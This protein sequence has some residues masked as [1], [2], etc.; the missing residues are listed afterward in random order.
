MSSIGSGPVGIP[1]IVSSAAG[2]TGQ[3]KAA[4][5]NRVN[6]DGNVR[7]FQMDRVD[8]FEKAVGDIDASDG[9]DERDADGR[10][11]WTFQRQSPSSQDDSGPLTEP[12]APDITEERG[13]QLDLDA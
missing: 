12:H 9:T 2:V 7:R 11:P 4:D 3:Q 8:Q 10:M 13:R 5:A 1:P 6:Q